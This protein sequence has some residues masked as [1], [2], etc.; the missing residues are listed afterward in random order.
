MALSASAAAPRLC[1]VDHT[2]RPTWKL[3]E[4][5]RFYRDVMGLPLIHAVTAKGWGRGDEHPDFLHFFFDAGEGS[6]IAFFYYIG[7]EQPE[8]MKLP[9]GY[10][11]LSNHTAWAVKSAEELKAWKI[12]LEAA[13]VRVSEEIHHEV[14][15][16]IYFRDPNGYPIE[17]SLPLRQVE[18]M[19]AED[20]SLT[21]Q[22]ALTL[23]DRGGWTQIEDMWKMKGE[24][25]EA[26]L[27]AAE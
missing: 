24:L 19:D 9:R 14:T 6:S 13:G 25:V 5:V 15:A 27:M 22:A 11:S 21:V 17:I 2:A 8:S 3:A 4:T 10:L 18:R 7:T 1:G 12:K 20:A 23:A 16:S 26:R